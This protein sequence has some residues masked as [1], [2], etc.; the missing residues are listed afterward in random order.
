[1]IWF[2]QKKIKKR[3]IKSTWYDWPIDYFLEPIKKAVST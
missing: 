2:E 1:M 3:P